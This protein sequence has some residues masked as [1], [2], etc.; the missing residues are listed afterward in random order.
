MA[1]WPKKKA[2]GEKA[3]CV[4]FVPLSEAKAYMDEK[5]RAGWFIHGG[6]VPVSGLDPATV[7]ITSSHT[8][9]PKKVAVKK[10]VEAVSE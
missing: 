9:W 7:C 4:E 3:S 8:V 10:K 6:A 5:L 1:G 2:G